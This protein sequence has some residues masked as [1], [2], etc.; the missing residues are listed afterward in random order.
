MP[1]L[2]PI[3]RFTTRSGA[4]IYRIAFDFMPN[5]SG[6][7]YLLLGAGAP[8]LVDAG[9]PA[10]TETIWAGLST[11]GA[12]FGESFRPEDLR[13]ILVTHAHVDHY[14]GLAEIVRRTGAE[15][16]VHA[17]DRRVVSAGLERLMIAEHAFRAFLRR[18]GVAEADRSRLLEGF[19]RTKRRLES[20]PVD[21][22]LE[23]G[24]DIDG[25]RVFHTP[26]H[27]PG[28]V[29]LLVDDV[30]LAGD[31]I[32]SRTITQQWPESIAPYTGLGHYLESLDK[33]KGI[34]DISL[35]MG[36][37]EPPVHDVYDRIESIRASHMRRI[38]R[39]L[40]VLRDS[41]QPLTIDE[42]TGRLYDRQTAFHAFLAL[43]DVA[44]RVEYLDERGRLAVANLDEIRDE[45]VP[46]Y[47]YQVA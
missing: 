7:V 35:V 27:S 40:A 1:N 3:K 37:H 13:R 47:R 12:E 30:L 16:G 46:A 45:E 18:A 24:R 23:E 31:H 4:R 28:H 36:G 32:L 41:P 19:G 17:L 25:V 33:V 42:I 8:V 38:D 21:L 43:T 2:P 39:V 22:L 29:C 10:A 11:V 9:S 34:P 15:I 20:V 6:R 5:L 26:G 44:A 14:G